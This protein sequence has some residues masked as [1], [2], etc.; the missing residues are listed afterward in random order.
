MCTEKLALTMKL[1]L[2]KQVEQNPPNLLILK[3]ESQ[4][5]I[6]RRPTRISLVLLLK[7]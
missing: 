5:I 4:I 2:L 6:I 3:P 7:L 1:L